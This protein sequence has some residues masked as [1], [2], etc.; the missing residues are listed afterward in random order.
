MRDRESTEETPPGSISTSLGRS[1][2]S[3]EELTEEEEELT[4][5][6]EEDTRVEEVTE[7]E[8]VEATREE[9]TREEEEEGTD[10]RVVYSSSSL[11]IPP[12]TDL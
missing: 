4:V 6:R 8:T 3:E 10:R 9:D 7:E 12:T 11:P 2:R 5:D 1:D